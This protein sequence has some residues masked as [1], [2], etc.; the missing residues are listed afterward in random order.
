MP[1]YGRE[2]WE[3]H[4]VDRRLSPE[5]LLAIAEGHLE[6]EEKLLGEADTYLF[7]D[8]NA[9]TTLLFAHYYHG[10]AL[11][12][13]EEIAERAAKRYDIVF[14]CDTDIAYEETWDRSGEVNRETFQDMVLADLENREVPY[15]LLGGGLDLRIRAVSGALEGYRK[16]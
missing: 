9:L 8:T 12:R 5:Q 11:P 16:Y 13:L 6:G 10:R 3:K 7:T 1:E 14:V 2:Y 15:T 4:Q